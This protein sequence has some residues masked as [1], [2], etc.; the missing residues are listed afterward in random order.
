MVIY[1]LS[2]TRPWLH[3]LKWLAG[4]DITET[5][6]LQTKN[7]KSEFDFHEVCT[8]CTYHKFIEHEDIFTDGAV[9][10]Q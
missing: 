7:G 10:L 5:F 6:V 4:R 2:L 1:L 8:Y 9:V 3:E